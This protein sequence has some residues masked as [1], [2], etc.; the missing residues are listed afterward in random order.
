MLEAPGELDRSMIGGLGATFQALYEAVA[1]GLLAPDAAQMLAIGEPPS[2]LLYGPP[3]CGK[4]LLARTLAAVLQEETGRRCHFAVVRPGEFKSPY[5]GE[6]EARIRA[7]FAALRRTAKDDEIVVLF[8]DELDS[9]GRI[10]G[11]ASSQHADSALGALL[12]EMS[13][14]ETRGNVAIIAATNRKE[15][16]DPAVVSRFQDVDLPVGRPNRRAADAIFRIHLPESVPFADTGEE[17]PRGAAVAAAVSALYAPNAGNAIARIRLRD[18]T[19]RDVEAREL[20][21]GR[22]ISQLVRSAKRRALARHHRGGELGIVSEDLQIAVADAVAD[23]AHLLTPENA[24]AQLGDLPQDV[25]V[26]RVEPLRP[27]VARLARV[28]HV[29]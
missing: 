11:G 20:V 24:R 8:L 25:D 22:L 4:T 21:S 13:G 10:R 1:L 5:V 16:L 9:I 27:R 3:G 2:A 15:L 14:F 6:T 18:G 12:V 26:V 29:A 7:C 28:H 19:T 23:L 17:D